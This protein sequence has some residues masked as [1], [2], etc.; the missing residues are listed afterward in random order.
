MTPLLEALLRLLGFAVRAVEEKREADAADR[1]RPLLD[2]EEE[3][4][5][6]NEGTDA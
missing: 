5:K 2:I 4:R 6:A 1:E 3:R